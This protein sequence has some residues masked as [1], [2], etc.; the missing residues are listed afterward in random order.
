MTI[1]EFKAK[2]PDLYQAIFDKGSETGYSDGFA[3]GEA[4]GIEKGKAKGISEA[5]KAGADHERARI[6]A[7]QEQLIPGHEDLI[8]ALMWD[9]KTTGEQAAIQV[10]AAE[11]RIRDK[12]A[13]DLKTDA[14]EPAAH[15]LPPETEQIEEN[16]GFLELVSAYEQEH[17][18][19]RSVAIK[20]IAKLHPK[21]HK[22]YLAE[23]NK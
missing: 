10:L 21:E 5:K 16:K 9:G 8:D 15:A 3:K 18:C 20:A 11:K 2:Y 23:N 6:R 22:A 12:T 7:V 17:E 4:S 13:A 14:P 1:D 19:K